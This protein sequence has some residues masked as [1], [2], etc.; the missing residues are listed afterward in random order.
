M[1][2]NWSTAFFVFLCVSCSC[3]FCGVRAGVAGYSSGRL[4][5]A[6]AAASAVVLFFRLSMCDKAG[7]STGWHAGGT[8]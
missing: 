4:L 7:R 3:S 6:A 5:N 8:P 2:R 1:G